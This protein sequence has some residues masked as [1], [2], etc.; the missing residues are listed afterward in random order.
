MEKLRNLQVKT[1]ANL[2]RK[3][4][5][6]TESFLVTTAQNRA[7][8]VIPEK[9]FGFLDPKDLL[10]CRLVHSSWKEIV[11]N[12]NFWLQILKSK[13]MVQYD[14]EMWKLFLEDTKQDRVRK[15]IKL[16]LMKLAIAH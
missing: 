7:L 14:V 6:T 9:I 2:L 16:C 3:P 12:P 8:N 15:E 13:G 11:D 5:L 10:Q 1:L 4:N